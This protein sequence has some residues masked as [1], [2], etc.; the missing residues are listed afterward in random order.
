MK[1]KEGN[2][3]KFASKKKKEK[4]MDEWYLLVNRKNGKSSEEKLSLVR[5]AIPSGLLHFST[6]FHVCDSEFHPLPAGDWLQRPYS[7]KSTYNGNF[8]ISTCNTLL[9]GSQKTSFYALRD[10]RK[11]FVRLKWRRKN[12]PRYI[13]CTFS[14]NRIFYFETKL[15]SYEFLK[16]ER[17]K[18]LGGLVS[19]S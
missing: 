6:V 13:L 15:K 9:N 14:Q 19:R 17:E 8:P 11:K 2:C 18:K 7:W 5:D 10:N 1:K 12:K 3:K 4:R 16:K